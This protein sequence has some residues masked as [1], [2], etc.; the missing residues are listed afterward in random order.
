MK[1]VCIR[2]GLLLWVFAFLFQGAEAAARERILEMNVFAAV[3]PDSTLSVTEEIIVV[4]EGIDIRRGII[5]TF[6]VK[7]KVDGRTHEVGF[8]LNSATLDGR[9][10]EYSVE[11][12]GSD[13][14]IRLGNARTMLSVGTH[15]Y[16]LTY[17]TTKQIRF[18][19]DHD[20]LYWNV[21]GNDWYL[22]IEKASFRVGLPNGVPFTDHYAYTGVW[23]ARGKD[24]QLD[25]EGVFRTTRALM[26]LEGF[27]VAVGWPKGIVTPPPPGFMEKYW[28]IIFILSIAMMIGW[29]VYAWMR[30]GRDPR[31]GVV[32]PLFA[33]PDGT[34]PGTVRYIKELKYDERA[35][36]GD[37]L[38]LAVEGLLTIRDM[39]GIELVGGAMTPERSA[40]LEAMPERLRAM[41]GM[42]FDRAEKIS[43]AGGEE[44]S[45]KIL[46]GLL[47]G[48]QSWFTAEPYYSRNILA[49]LAGIPFLLPGVYAVLNA[50]DT[51][52]IGVLI[53]GIL[54][55]LA[56]IL[57][58]FFLLPSRTPLGRSLLDKIEG[59]IL[60]LKTAETLRLE[61]FYPNVRGSVPE[62][63]PLQFERFLPYALALDTA[64][65]WADGFASVLGRSYSP[66]W[67]V[68]PHGNVL[69]GLQHLAGRRLSEGLRASAIAGMPK[70][71]SGSGSYSGG[72][73]GLGGGG[74][75]GG[76]GGGGGGRG[77]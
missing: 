75:S 16:V 60:Y 5:R 7:Y 53:A 32:F 38:L 73:S 18:F 71:A 74:F 55:A 54:S 72:G 40:K 66:E 44:A 43:L 28:K 56:G 11:H 42:L 9:P 29:Y 26:P 70:P 76:G 33:P 6:P 34:D 35:L 1:S 14:E 23:G 13:V 58:F 20:E 63:T 2:S 69:P 8:K 39:D 59:F 17:T 46:C 51:F 3:R 12:A 36:G 45:S 27:S 48:M 47:L 19:D 31:R 50:G 57:I 77:W 21:T 68:A 49:W 61:T 37:I 62:Q 41:R 65:T 24:F 15:T 52:S 22:A 25:E 64:D 10:V 67:Y 30:W 4:A